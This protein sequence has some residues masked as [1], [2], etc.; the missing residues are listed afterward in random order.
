VEILQVE[1]RLE[2]SVVAFLEKKLKH[3]V[4]LA[5]LVLPEIVG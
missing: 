4:P 3:C 1:I 2:K 5:P